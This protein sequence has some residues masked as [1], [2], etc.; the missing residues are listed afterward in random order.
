MN[1]GSNASTNEFKQYLFRD[2][3][4]PVL[5]TTDTN[6]EAAD[7]AT[8]IMLKEWCD[9]NK[10]ELSHLFELVQEYRPERKEDSICGF[11]KE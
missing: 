1:N 2:L 10:P 5:K 8:M 11:Y 6:R 9:Q 7:D 4:L 3:G